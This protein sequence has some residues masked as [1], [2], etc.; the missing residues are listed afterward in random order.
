MTRASSTAS[1]VLPAAVGPTRAIIRGR[2]MATSAYQAAGYGSRPAYAAGELGAR[3]LHQHRPAVRAGGGE[4]NRIEIGNQP[5]HLLGKERIARAHRTVARDPREQSVTR[6]VEAGARAQL[7][8]LGREVAQQLLRVG[9]HIERRRYR[10]H[11]HAGL[12]EGLDVEAG[13]G[14]LLPDLRKTCTGEGVELGDA[15]REKS[16]GSARGRPSGAQ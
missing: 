16:L 9:A 12:A 13:C 11:E 10:T 15:R 2:D 7:R 6:T 4:G 1:G 8:K 14:E 3:D 5:L